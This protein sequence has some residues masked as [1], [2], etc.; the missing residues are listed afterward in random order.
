[1]VLLITYEL[2]DKSRDI[3]NLKGEIKKAGTWWHHL[4]NVWIIET[5]KDEDKWYDTLKPHLRPEDH[6]YIVKITTQQQG[7]LPKGAWDW[8]ENRKYE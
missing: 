2:F 3:S 1:M 6:I 8:L 7:W 4:E 5:E